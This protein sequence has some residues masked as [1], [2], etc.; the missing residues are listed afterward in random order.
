LCVRQ[1]RYP[2]QRWTVEVPAGTS[3]PGETPEQAAQRELGEET[4]YSC[5]RLV[6]R[7][8]F[9]PSVGV[10]DEL[11]VVFEA[12]ELGSTARNP[13]KGELVRPELVAL[14]DIPRLVAANE[15]CDGKTLLVLAL[16]GLLPGTAS[17]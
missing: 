16:L 4:G 5:A 14:D 9:N 2:L 15:I 17:C 6:E 7:L 8:R 13:D 3:D 1:Y 12:F 11:M 10:C